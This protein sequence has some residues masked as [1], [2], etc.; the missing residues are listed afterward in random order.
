MNKTYRTLLGALLLSA[1]LLGGCAPKDAAPPADASSGPESSGGSSSQPEPAPPVITFEGTDL[2][3]N[4]HTS[5]GLAAQSRLTMVNVW[6]TNCPPCLDEMPALGELAAAYDQSEFQLIGVIAD[7][8]E[9]GDQSL[10]ESLIDETGANYPHL[11]FNMSIYQLLGD[12]ITTPTT[13]FLDQDGILLRVVIGAM[14]K[15]YWEDT[16]NELLEGL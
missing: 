6:A 13:F 1:L 4:F 16:I 15:E 9:G 2:E 3:G 11:L 5:A 10:A 12:P 7:V 8:V 14:E